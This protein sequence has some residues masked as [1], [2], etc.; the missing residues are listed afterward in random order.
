MDRIPGPSN[1]R[2]V[3]LLPDLP[4]GHDLEI[5]FVPES[6]GAFDIAASDTNL[7]ASEGVNSDV[8]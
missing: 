3:F 5:R 6:H 8:N 2:P 7:I 1:K 4:N